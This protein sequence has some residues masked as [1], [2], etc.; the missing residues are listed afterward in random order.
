M[1]GAN[2]GEGHL[3]VCHDSQWHGV[4]PREGK[5]LSNEEAGKVCS[6]LGYSSKSE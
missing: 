3:E 6:H 5:E 4:C 1:G 2:K